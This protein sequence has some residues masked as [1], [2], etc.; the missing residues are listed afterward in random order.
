MSATSQHSYETVDISPLSAS[1]RV[2]T[3]SCEPM[4]IPRHH[5]VGE[6]GTAVMK[7]NNEYWLIGIIIILVMVI[8]MLVVYAVKLKNG[9]STGADGDTKGRSE[10]KSA[11][12]KTSTQSTTKPQIAAAQPQDDA[13]IDVL[14][15]IAHSTF[16]PRSVARHREDIDQRSTRAVTP[17]VRIEAV[18]SSERAP[19]MPPRASAPVDGP[20]SE[21]DKTAQ[22]PQQDSTS[23]LRTSQSHQD[24]AD[25]ADDDAAYADVVDDHQQQSIEE[26][27]STEAH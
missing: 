5:D 18:S 13:T 22:S 11:R 8:I 20:S 15:E 3:S 21:S 27:P 12:T 23:P 2:D 19:A 7:M 1:R 9:A 16:V 10:S 4:P 25:G 6:I 17:T 24:V 14:H 26:V